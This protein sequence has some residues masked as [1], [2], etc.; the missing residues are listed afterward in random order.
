MT[1]YQEITER[2]SDYTIECEY[3]HDA[4]PTRTANDAEIEDHADAEQYARLVDYFVRLH[5]P[6]ADIMSAI[7]FELQNGIDVA[8]GREFG[9][10]AEVWRD[11]AREEIERAI[12]E[13]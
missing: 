2:D 7:G 6:L 12:S 11:R 9:Q 10:L 8:L 5:S 13:E 3:W 4:L 1:R